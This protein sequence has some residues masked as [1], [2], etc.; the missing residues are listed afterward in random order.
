MKHS[1]LRFAAPF[2][3]ARMSVV[4]KCVGSAGAPNLAYLQ[5]PILLAMIQVYAPL[6]FVGSVHTHLSVLCTARFVNFAE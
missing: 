3:A 1:G 6:Q 2:R 5:K 4:T